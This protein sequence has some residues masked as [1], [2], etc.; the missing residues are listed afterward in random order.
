MAVSSL[1]PPRL[2][3]CMEYV[4]ILAMWVNHFPLLSSVVPFTEC[5]YVF[6]SVS[7]YF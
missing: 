7:V 6:S 1:I 4:V 5:A 3:K 2:W